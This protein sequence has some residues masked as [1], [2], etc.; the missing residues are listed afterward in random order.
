MTASADDRQARSPSV[1]AQG[2]LR[3]TR[4]LLLGEWSRLLSPT[5]SESL[6]RVADPSRI[7]FA[8]PCVQTQRGERAARAGGASYA[9][10]GNREGEGGFV[11]LIGVR[12]VVA[13]R[14]RK[15]SLHRPRRRFTAPAARV[16]QRQ[17]TTAPTAGRPGAPAGRAPHWLGSLLRPCS[18]ARGKSHYLDAPEMSARPEPSS[19]R[20]TLHI[21]AAPGYSPSLLPSLPPWLAAAARAAG[22]RPVPGRAQQT[23]AARGVQN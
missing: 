23:G 9:R 18:P 15:L 14:G 20:F 16:L 19:I 11:S 8:D 7:R 4:I 13:R 3:S 6:I 5:R 12:R 17:H 21:L 2:R 10:G 22:A 1:M